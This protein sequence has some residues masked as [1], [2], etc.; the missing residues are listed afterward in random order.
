MK[1]FYHNKIGYNTAVI[2]CKKQDIFFDLHYHLYD[3]P[4]QH[5][6]QKMHL[7]NDKGLKVCNFNLIPFKDLVDELTKCCIEVNAELPPKQIDQFYL[8]RLHNSFVPNY[9]N[10]VW[11]RINDLIH[12]IESKL[13][14]P[15]HEYDASL[16]LNLVE[17][18]FVPISEEY[19]IFLDTDIKW[20]RLNLGYGTLGK[21]WLNIAKNNDTLDDLSIQNTINS[22]T[23]MSFCVEPGIPLVDEIKFY[24]WALNSSLSIPKNNLNALSLGKYPLGQII[25]TDVLLDFHNI[26][27]DWYVPNHQCK[28]LWNKHFFNNTVNI[29]EISFKNTDMLYETYIRDSGAKGILNV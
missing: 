18:Q 15:F 4:V 16:T 19:K 7:I 8:N 13:N 12:A 20:G 9:D 1:E 22:E 27:S 17:E 6:W 23:L 21:D 24:N 29:L 26:A 2:S 28:L 14:N 10:K 25:I 11:D 3:N 5:I